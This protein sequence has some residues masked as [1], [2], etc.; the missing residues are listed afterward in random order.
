VRQAKK[1]LMEPNLRL[2]V[3]VAKRYLGS[4]LSL[5]GPDPGGQHR[6][7]EAVDRFQYRRGFKFSTYATC[8]SARRSRAPSPTTR[9]RSD[10]VHMVETLTGSLG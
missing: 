3:S 7:D 8:G 5:L 9:G 2:V 10:P 6:A 4:D 1:E